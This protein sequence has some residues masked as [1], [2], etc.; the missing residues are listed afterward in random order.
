MPSQRELA[1]AFRSLHERSEIFVIPNPWDAG[2]AKVLASLGFSAL[3]TSSAGSAAARG[4]LDG[5]LSR[6]E[7]MDHAQEIAGAVSVPVSADL[8]DGFARSPEGIAETARQALATGIAGFSIQDSTGDPAAPIL[9]PSLA[10]ERVR[11]AAEVAHGGPAH[12]ILTAR[13]ENH[14]R[15]RADL[16]DTVSRLQSYVEA[17]ADVVFAPGLSDLDDIRAVV[18][19]VPAPVNVL[20]RAGTPTAAK[21]GDVGV[22]RVS[23]GSAFV[24]VALGAVIDAAAELRDH[25][26][27]G[28][29][30]AMAHGAQIARRAL[31]D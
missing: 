7:A 3:A 23:I 15:Q 30:D 8:E 31:G 28:Y 22:R 25:G 20:V 19:S 14:L 16:A 29:L 17:G 10:A 9:E 24:W 13:A 27:Y 11:A 12:L 1:E 26:T 5:T 6:R 2:S 18:T 21:L 4:R